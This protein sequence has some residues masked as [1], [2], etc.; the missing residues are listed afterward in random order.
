MD[1]TDEVE[2]VSESASDT[3]QN[4]TVYGRNAAGELV[5]EQI[6]LTGQTPAAGLIAFERLL[7]AVKSAI[8][9]GTVAVMHTVNET[10][11][12]AQGGGTDYIT[13][14]AGA[15]A[16][17]NAYQFMVI[18]ITGGTGINQI[19]EV[20]EYN[21][22]TK[23]ADV[24]DWSTG[25]DATSVYE[26]AVGMV[27][28]KSPNEIDECRRPFYDV[29]ADPPG[30]IDKD[31]YDKIFV[32]N[33]HP[34]LALTNAKID[35]VVEGGYAKV[36]FALESSLDGL[37]TNGA[38]NNRQVAPS[39]GIGPFNSNVKDVANSGNFSPES[40]QGLWLHLDLA[41]GDAADNTYYKLKVS[42]QST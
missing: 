38:G 5:N 10:S 35:E 4:V 17:D 40:G 3:S 32:Y 39:A 23:Q 42:G 22:T 37:G 21:G 6:D 20:V 27:M 16:V 2:V 34:T 24:R 7:K 25:P 9:A 15:S 14:A 12:T 31:Y 30:G 19:R 28:D 1:T 29:A 8:C 41:A 18:R 11:G 26:I 13:L 36:E 33:Q